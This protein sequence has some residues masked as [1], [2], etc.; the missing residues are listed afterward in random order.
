[1]NEWNAFDYS[2]DY[3]NDCIYD[4][5]TLMAIEKDRISSP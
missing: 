1:M 5:D 2:F 4:F 3:G